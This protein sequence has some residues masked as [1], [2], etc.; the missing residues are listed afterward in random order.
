MPKVEPKFSRLFVGLGKM[1]PISDLDRANAEIERLE[2]HV[3]S[4][5]LTIVDLAACVRSARVKFKRS[6]FLAVLPTRIGL[7]GD[8][9]AEAIEYALDPKID[10][11]FDEC[12]TV[13][14]IGHG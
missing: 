11:L 4:Q 5:R 14:E 7:C 3:E 8:P 2:E 10:R 12:G 13:T 6:V 9:I 1:V